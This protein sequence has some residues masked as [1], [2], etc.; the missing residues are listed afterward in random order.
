MEDSDLNLQCEQQKLQIN[1]L[2]LMIREKDDVLQNKDKE[3]QVH[4]FRIFQKFGLLLLRLSMVDFNM[5]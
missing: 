1:Q 4:F 5:I 2:K 3:I